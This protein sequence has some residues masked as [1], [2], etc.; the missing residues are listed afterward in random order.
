MIMERDA[1][2][3]KADCVVKRM[4]QQYL[5]R[6]ARVNAALARARLGE[7]ARLAWVAARVNSRGVQLAEAVGEA[8][9]ELPG[10]AVDGLVEERRLPAD[11]CNT[12]VPS[13]VVVR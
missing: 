12:V 7:Q 3:S 10:G 1:R 2:G 13:G 4:R 11:R 6:V 9:V 5:A 8:H